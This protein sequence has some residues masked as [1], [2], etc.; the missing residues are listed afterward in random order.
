MIVRIAYVIPLVLVCLF[1]CRD[2]NQQFAHQQKTAKAHPLAAF[3]ERN[4]D[5]IAAATDRFQRRLSADGTVPDRALLMARDQRDAV[6]SSSHGIPA[7]IAR[8][9]WTW[10]GPGN[11]GGRLRPIV[12]HPTNPD[13]IY[14]GSASGGIWKTLDGGQ[15]WFALDDFLPSLA[16]ADMVMH[17]DDPDT[18]FAGSGEGFF[19]AP[20]GSSNTAF[21]R[22]AGIF[23]STDAGATWNQMPSTDNPDFYFV[24]RLVFDPVD[25]NT[26]LVAT[27][28]GIWRTKDG[29]LTW[30]LRQSLEAMDVKF[31]PNNPL[32]VVAGGHDIVGGPYYSTDGGITW[33]Q[34]SGA[35]GERQEF[36]WAPNQSGIVYAAVA[37]AG[38]IK[39]WRSND[40]GQSYSLQTTG[41]GISTLEAYTGTIWVDPTDADFLIVGG[42]RLFSST[43]GGA[44]LTQNFNAVHADM[45]RIVPHPDFDAVKNKTV[46][47]ATDG[48]IYQT[49][50]VYGSSAFGLNNNL[51]VTQ[52]YGGAIN[53][54]TGDI[55]GGTQDNGTLFYSGD[56]QNWFHLFG[57]DGGY[58]A[59]DPTDPNYFYGEVQ[60]AL[61]HRSTDGGQSADYI[62]NGPNPISDAG[63]S[64]TVNFIPF[65]LLD[66][67]DP[68]RMLVACERMWRSNN[69]KDPV[70][71]WFPIKDSIEPPGGILPN[72]ERLAQS[73][74]DPNSPFN[75]S[76]IAIAE[77]NSDI[78]WAAHNNGELYFTT[79][80]TDADPSWTRVDLN[81]V[82]LPS[83]WIST[84]VIDR[85]DHSHVYV[86]LMGWEDDNLWETTDGGLTWTDI[87]GA[88]AKSIPMPR[89]A[90]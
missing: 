38:R 82:G 73:H 56:P 28:T 1:G 89:S 75:L 55:V 79:N 11:I 53:P 54:T 43:D 12:I 6:L 5:P 59:A 76:T 31:D 20:E 52:F 58:G 74:Y 45:H 65:F 50:D 71:D 9:S 88:G 49:D 33:Q 3:E 29:G 23:E 63:S 8:G 16:I 84:V 34:A 13:I 81:G 80:G 36:A 69:V 24:N 51:G 48:G 85:N 37:D 27:L 15:S 66:P 86:A 25:A 67:N 72:T 30:S 57:G 46:Y 77:G 14:I 7:G 41:E 83:R 47:F 19:E 78:V 21:V 44:T 26:M 35:E 18:L 61:I 40:N 10:L 32:Y 68:N 87:S 39:V 42:Q 4:D 60:R 70:P 22:G 2:A 17:P 90:R 64:A 62:Y